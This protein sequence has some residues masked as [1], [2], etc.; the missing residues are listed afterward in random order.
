MSKNKY[1]N[2]ILTVG[3]LAII[4]FGIVIVKSLDHNRFQMEMVFGRLYKIGSK[5]I[6]I[7]KRIDEL[8]SVKIEKRIHS[9]QK[10]QSVPFANR[11]FFDPNAVEGGRMII[12]IG[13]QYDLQR[14]VLVT[15]QGDDFQQVILDSVAFVPMLPGVAEE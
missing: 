14:L 9:V 10:K 15:R 5:L 6:E 7:E 11:E 8:S 1:L 12:P 4:F 2:F 13:A 3:V